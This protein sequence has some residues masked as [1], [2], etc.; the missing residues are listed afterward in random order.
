MKILDSKNFIDGSKSLIDHLKMVCFGYLIA[1]HN[2]CD[3][4][5]KIFNRF[6]ES[7]IFGLADRRL[8]DLTASDIR[9]NYIA[10]NNLPMGLRH[11]PPSQRIFITLPRRRTGM[12]ATLAFVMANGARGS[13]PSLQAYPSF[14]ANELHVRE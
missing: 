7:I 9:D 13:S 10:Y 3:L 1:S 11:H 4:I 8:N 12:P 14:R 6:S 2:L 5:K